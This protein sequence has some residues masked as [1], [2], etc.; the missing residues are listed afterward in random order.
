M[1]ESVC[2]INCEKKIVFVILFIIKKLHFV[3]TISAL[4]KC[5]IVHFFYHRIFHSE[6]IS[7]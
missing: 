6:K 2:I 5:T 3:Q 4:Q 1:H 7:D